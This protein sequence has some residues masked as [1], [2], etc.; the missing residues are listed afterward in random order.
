MRKAEGG[1]RKAEVRATILLG[2][3]LF[4]FPTIAHA[5]PVCFGNG[6]GPMIDWVNNGLW[7]LLGIL[8]VVQ[9]GFVALFWSFWR[10]AK[11]LRQRREQFH[12]IQGGIH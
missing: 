5:C 11:A 12:L 10:R 3:A 2:L 9:A 7:V 1:R 8:A 4:L 6:S